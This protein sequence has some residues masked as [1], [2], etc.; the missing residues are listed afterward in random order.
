MTDEVIVIETDNPL[1]VVL[2]EEET[3]ALL[4]FAGDYMADEVIVIETDNPLFVVL[5]EEET[6]AL[7]YLEGVGPKGDPGGA[8]NALKDPVFT[9]NESGDLTRVDYQ[10]GSY[11]IFTY[12]SNGNLS[13]LEYLSNST[14][15]IRTFI[16]VN[17]VLQRIED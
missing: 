12:D 14:F 10:G 16:Y 2:T 1:F 15:G 11:K 6:T 17:D 9:Y 7:L 4:Y 5:T 3:T 13:R 8:A